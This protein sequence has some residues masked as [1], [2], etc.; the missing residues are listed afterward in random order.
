MTDQPRPAVRVPNWVHVCERCG[1]R[2]EER[3]C[4]ITCRNCGYS[5][6]CSDP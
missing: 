3:Q 6:D 1:E 2:M 4:K 5:R